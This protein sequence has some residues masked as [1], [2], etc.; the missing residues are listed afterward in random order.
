M[1]MPMVECSVVAPMMAAA[2]PVEAVEQLLG[3]CSFGLYMWHLVLK[4]CRVIK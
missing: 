3:Q 1:P 2:Q 4:V